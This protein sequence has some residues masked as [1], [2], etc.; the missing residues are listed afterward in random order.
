MMN[1]TWPK[2]N[3]AFSAGLRGDQFPGASP[4]ARYERRAFSALNGY[5]AS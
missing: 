5:L 2:V 1:R 4:Q 3:R